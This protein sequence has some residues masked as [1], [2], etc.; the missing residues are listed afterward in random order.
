[1]VDHLPPRSDP[2]RFPPGS[3]RINPRLGVMSLAA[4]QFS[5]EKA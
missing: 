3:L 4:K 2:E 1:L 5:Q